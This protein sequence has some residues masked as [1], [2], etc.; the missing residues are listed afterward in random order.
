MEK[1]DFFVRN[2]FNNDKL[3][4]GSKSSDSVYAAN[5]TCTAANPICYNPAL[6][7]VISQGVSTLNMI[8]LALPEK[9][10]FGM[11]ASV[12]F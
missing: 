8:F 1:V 10:T 9:R 4:G 3:V 6:A 7:T 5:A 12:E 2:L 11:R